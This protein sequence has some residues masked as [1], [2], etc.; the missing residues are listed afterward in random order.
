MP[1][2]VLIVGPTETETVSTHG[3][4]P[5]VAAEP[6]RLNYVPALDG[7]R[8]IAILAVLASHMF[9]PLGSG[10]EGVDVFFVL[11]GFLITTLLLQEHDS[12]GRISLRA[13]WWRRGARLLPALFVMAP[14]VAVA[15]ALIKPDGWRMSE[16]GVVSSLLY[17]SAWMRASGASELGW[18]GQTWSLSVEEWFYLVWPLG[19]IAVLRRGSHLTGWVV[20]AACLAVAYRLASEQ[21][22]LPYH[23]LYNA[24]DQRASQL[25]IGCA[26]GAGLFALGERRSLHG[27]AFVAAG[28]IGALIVGVTLSGFAA[29]HA[30]HGF[31]YTSGQSTVIALGSAAMIVSLVVVPGWLLAKTLTWRPL[32]WVGRRSYGLY[33]WHMPIF[34]LVLL[35]HHEI[36]GARLDAERLLAIGLSFAAAA[37]SFRYVERPVIRWVRSREAEKRWAHEFPAAVPAPA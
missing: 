6:N 4:G 34:G 21:S 8:A 9:K 33:L 28:V 10:G 1:R 3:P 23:Y 5:E 26:A 25:L 24:P 19:M 15:F 17:V 30:S 11:S 37:I 13:F 12:T 29:E 36:T 22:G 35:G 20:G 2:S 31:A 27:R 14:I 7:V 16:L 18:M 32:V